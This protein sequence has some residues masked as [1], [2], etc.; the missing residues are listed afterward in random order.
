MTTTMGGCLISKPRRM[1]VEE[2]TGQTKPI[3]EQ[4]RRQRCF[5]GALLEPLKESDLSHGIDV[6][7]VTTT[8]EVGVDIGSLSAVVLGNMPPQRFNY[9]QRVGR[10]GRAGQ[11]FSYA[12][13]MCRDRTHDDFY[14]NHA[15]RITG[16]PPPQPYLDASV[17]IL[18][19][20]AAAECLRRAFLSLG[21]GPRPTRDSL[22]GAF[23]ANEDWLGKYRDRIQ[24]WLESAQEVVDVVDGLRPGTDL[25]DEEADDLAAW[26][27][28]EL[29]DLIDDV[30]Q[31]PTHKSPE[32][33]QTL[34]SGGLLPM[35]GFP[36]RVRA[37]I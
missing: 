12:V 36:T 23:G 14:F 20:V 9:Q 3:A 7:S 30:S 24:A 37:A 2:L 4:R 16:D 19:R 11:K 10:A 6:L 31:D 5:K 34:A 29:V 33:S 26:I 18:R 17:P 1:R 27:R 13:T 21:G 15:E 22:H 28:S 32:L 25:S 35:F 8:M